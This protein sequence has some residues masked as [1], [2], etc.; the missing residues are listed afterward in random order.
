M[1]K[2]ERAQ[3]AADTEVSHLAHLAVTE[4][5]LHVT[6]QR[7]APVIHCG[8]R[9]PP[10]RTSVATRPVG[11]NLD[12][13]SYRVPI[14]WPSVLVPGLSLLGFDSQPFQCLKNSI[15]QCTHQL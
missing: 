10:H 8:S 14:V 7:S 2:E 11:V 1:L 4:L 9:T 3:Y 5:L 6:Q 15:L 12:Q 13:L